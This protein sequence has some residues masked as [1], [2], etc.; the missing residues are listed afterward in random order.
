[1]TRTESIKFAKAQQKAAQKIIKIISDHTA[2][3]DDDTDFISINDAALE[4]VETANDTITE[5]K[6]ER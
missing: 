3:Y 6:F 5:C 1:M 4:I 2:K